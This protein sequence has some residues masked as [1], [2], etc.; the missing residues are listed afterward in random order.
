MKCKVKSRLIFS[1]FYECRKE[2]LPNFD[3]NIFPSKRLWKYAPTFVYFN[4]PQG[5][6]W[7]SQVAAALPWRKGMVD[8]YKPRSG[9]LLSID[10]ARKQ[11]LFQVPEQVITFP[12]SKAHMWSE[13]CSAKILHLDSFYQ[14][15]YQCIYPDHLTLYLEDVSRYIIPYL[16]LVLYLPADG[17][18]NRPV[19]LPVY[20]LCL[21]PIRRGFLS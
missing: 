7:V 17:P 11:H 21:H 12:A 5:V 2:Y 13:Q 18:T 9:R 16:S 3:P 4:S 14:L 1:L 20:L 10:Q 15:F 6:F 19:S 8:G